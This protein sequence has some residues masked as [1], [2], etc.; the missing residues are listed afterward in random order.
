MGLRRSNLRFVAV[1][2]EVIAG[3]VVLMVLVPKNYAHSVLTS[4]ISLA[5]CEG[6][7][8]VKPKGLR[9]PN[10]AFEVIWP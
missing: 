7:P 5:I 3:A 4:L 9:A 2:V 8:S 10:I 1:E 6:S